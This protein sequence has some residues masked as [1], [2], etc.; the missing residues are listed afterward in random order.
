ME[1]LSNGFMLNVTTTLLELA[2]RSGYV[3]T[4]SHTL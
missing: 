3:L 2:H 4:V 1:H